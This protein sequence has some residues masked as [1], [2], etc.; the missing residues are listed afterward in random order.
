MPVLSRRQLA[1][2]RLPERVNDQ[3]QRSGLPRAAIELEFGERLLLEEI[4][5]GSAALEPLRRF[6]LRVALGG[7]GSEVSS[8]RVLQEAPVH[9]LKLSRRLLEHVGEDSRRTGF[10]VAVLRL[11]KQLKLRVVAEGV[12]SDAQLKLL[13]REGCDAV[14]SVLSCPPLPPEGC[15]EWLRQAS[16][17]LFQ[18]PPAR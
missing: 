6:G 8:L 18:P 1:W 12:E 15:T 16:S 14:Q 7:F 5:A 9:T 10:A 3:L 17:R 13:R 4:E 11:A 2:S